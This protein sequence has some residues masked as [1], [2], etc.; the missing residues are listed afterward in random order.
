MHFP[1]AEAEGVDRAI[2]LG[3]VLAARGFDVVDLRP[4]DVRMRQPTIRYFEPRLRRE[5]EHLAEVVTGLLRDQGFET[6]KVR[7]QDFTFY[8]PKPR[9]NAIELWLAQ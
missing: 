7:V 1:R 4:V 9:R 8:E 3:G 6:G 2:V 5:A